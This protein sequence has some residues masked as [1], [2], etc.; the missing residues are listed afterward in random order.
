[1]S[2]KTTTALSCTNA[3]QRDVFS[4]TVEHGTDYTRSRG[5]LCCVR[6]EQLFVLRLDLKT[7][8]ANS[9]CLIFDNHVENDNVN[10]KL[11]EIPNTS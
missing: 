3:T 4:N 10:G 2:S 7:R 8:H 9:P 1:M 6:G 5:D 11:A